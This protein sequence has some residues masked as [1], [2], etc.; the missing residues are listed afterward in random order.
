MKVR[1]FAVMALAATALAGCTTMKHG[2][3]S[4]QSACRNERVTL[5]FDTASDGLT[6]DGRKLVELSARRL[7]SCKVKELQLLGLTD[8][9]GSPEENL[10]LSKRRADNVL[11]A[12]VRAGVPAPHYT[13][14]A[15]G[16]KGSV[17]PNGAVEPVRRRVD[18]TVVV[19]R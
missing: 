15:A 12:F 13:L 3:A 11:D 6:D 4:R 18:V 5:Y 10:Q 14:V 8:P 9:A 17:A 19:A 1:H 7:R 16:A 2:F